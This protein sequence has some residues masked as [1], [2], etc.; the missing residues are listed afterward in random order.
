MSRLSRLA[1]AAILAGIGV[2]FAAS[3]AQAALRM[4]LD[5]TTNNVGVVLTGAGGVVKFD[6][7]GP[8]PPVFSPS[9]S[10]VTPPATSQPGIP[11]G[12]PLLAV[13][14][15][16]NFTAAPTGPAPL[17]PTRAHPA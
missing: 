7:G 3:P 17:P 5:D 9:F 10:V 1:G 14:P 12:P 6:N 11:P 15:R 16:N 8:P 2:L 4:R 13:L